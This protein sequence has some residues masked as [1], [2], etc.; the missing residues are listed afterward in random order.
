MQFIWYEGKL[1]SLIAVIAVESAGKSSF[2]YSCKRTRLMVDTIENGPL[3]S[4]TCQN[5]W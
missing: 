2:I 5:S 4:L 1:D 3:A